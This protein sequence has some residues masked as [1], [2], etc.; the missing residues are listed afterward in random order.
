MQK[1]KTKRTSGKLSIGQFQKSVV[2][3]NDLQKGGGI[4]LELTLVRGHS[5]VAH[6][7]GLIIVNMAAYSISGK[8]IAN[9]FV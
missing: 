7:R 3:A 6:K 1:N 4:S 8:A 9:N 5:Q 2:K